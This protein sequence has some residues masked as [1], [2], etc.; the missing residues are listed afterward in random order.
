M[1][2]R[3]TVLL[4]AAVAAGVTVASGMIPGVAHVA[5]P[6]SMGCQADCVYVAGGWPFPFLVDQPGISPVGSVSLSGGLF[7]E[8][9]IGLGFLAA[10]YVFWFAV[11]AVT[12][13]I[14]VRLKE[15]VKARAG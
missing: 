5:Y 1:I 9:A 11:C 7:G 13:W 12:G 15:F 6:G 14:A 10:N 8:D 4:V 3:R 2:P